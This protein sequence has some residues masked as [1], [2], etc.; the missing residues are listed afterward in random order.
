MLP[1]SL[2]GNSK[3][4]SGL[5]KWKKERPIHKICHRTQSHHTLFKITRASTINSKIRELVKKVNGTNNVSIVK[6]CF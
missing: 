1:E 2:N 5:V 6:E 3:S 4:R